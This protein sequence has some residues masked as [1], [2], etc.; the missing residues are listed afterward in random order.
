MEINT[1]ETSSELNELYKAMAKT[2]A[3][4]K[5]II[6]A[7]SVNMDL[8]NGRK[9]Q[10]DYATLG[11][12]YEA[13]KSTA[14][15]NG[16]C[17]FQDIQT[18]GD[19]TFILTEI[20]HESGQYRRTRVVVDMPEYTDYNGKTR[21]PTFQ[22]FGSAITYLR[23]YACVGAFALSLLD[24]DALEASTN[25]GSRQSNSPFTEAKRAPQK[26]VDS[27]P[28]ESTK[29]TASDQ[30]PKPITNHAPKI[31]GESKIAFSEANSLKEAGFKNNWTLDLM[32][33]EVQLLVG[34]SDWT[35][36]QKKHIPVLAGLF[37]KPFEVPF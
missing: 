17:L 25:A 2:Q 30:Q 7:E 16:L 3:E 5:P 19:Q 32:N 14:H 36:L 28:K 20:G 22:E 29:T 11:Q 4:I 35:M 34:K 15:R 26:S 33:H 23:R 21:K 18:I 1:F 27:T 9:L 13:L 24:D 12:A 6:K 31:T 37:S 8:K 10:Y